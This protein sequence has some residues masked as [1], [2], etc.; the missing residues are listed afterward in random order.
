M[1]APTDSEA[2]KTAKKL[3]WYR[4]VGN[5]GIPAYIA[6]ITLDRLLGQ[7]YL[8]YPDMDRQLFVF[9]LIV[10]ALLPPIVLLG[11]RMRFTWGYIKCPD[12]NAPF[13]HPR[14]SDKAIP[15]ACWHCGF[16]LR[17]AKREQAPSSNR[18]HTNER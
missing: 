9:L 2:I 15:E 18:E 12:C 8:R 4:W 7:R 6:L 11:I 16:N 5:W 17:T 10:A 13:V 3:R 1:T 14:S